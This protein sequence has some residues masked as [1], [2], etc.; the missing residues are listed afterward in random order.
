MA[1]FTKKQAAE[2]LMK[3]GLSSYMGGKNSNTLKMNAL[4]MN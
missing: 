3:A 2:P 1:G 4:P